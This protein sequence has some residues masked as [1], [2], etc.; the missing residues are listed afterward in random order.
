[1]RHR[2]QKST[3]SACINLPADVCKEYVRRVEAFCANSG[4]PASSRSPSE[5][6]LPHSIPPFTTECASE[7]GQR[8]GLSKQIKFIQQ[9]KSKRKTGKK[10]NLMGSNGE[11]LVLRGAD[12]DGLHTKG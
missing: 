11:K 2:G 7:N 12:N 9:S 5:L 4:G 1:M 8:Q 3:S 10:N 6:P